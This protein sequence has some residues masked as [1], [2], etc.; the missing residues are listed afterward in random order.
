MLAL[1]AIVFV[2]ACSRNAPHKIDV[3]AAAPS[4]EPAH[5]EATFVAPPAPKQ[6][7]RDVT[8]IVS[9]VLQTFAPTPDDRLNGFHWCLGNNPK[10]T[11]TIANHSS[12]AF[13]LPAE[14]IGTVDIWKFQ[15]DGR[16]VM[17]RQ[18]PVN[19]ER[20]A[21]SVQ[22]RSMKLLQP[23]ESASFP[24]SMCSIDANSDETTE[25]P[26]VGPGRYTFTMSYNYDGPDCPGTVPAPTLHDTLV[27]EE[28]TLH[29]K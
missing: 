9:P 22:W 8:F 20:S 15:R 24:V 16:D 21:R 26:N 4:P 13:Y 6:A 23:G 28:I 3:V 5:P 17:P 7:R 10:L 1:V 11:A 29:V 14:E 2:V 12:S 19:Y 25:Y 18:V 27:S